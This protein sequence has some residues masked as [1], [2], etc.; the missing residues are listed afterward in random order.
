MK[1]IEILIIALLIGVTA[2]LSAQNTVEITEAE[3][4]IWQGKAAL[5]GYSP[6]GT[7][8]LEKGILTLDN[9][10][11][12]SLVVAVDMTT[13]SQE[14][15]RL[16]G[17]LRNEDFF[18]VEVFTQAVFTLTKP[19][20]LNAEETQLEGVMTIKNNSMNEVIPAKLSIVDNSIV[21][22]FDHQFDRTLY[23]ITYNSPT[24]FEKL[25][26]KAIAD[27]FNLRAKLS[28]PLPSN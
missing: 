2:D 5:G 22:S 18:D 26:D 12:T 6:E 10:T 4:I 3:P 14:N 27:E 21:I 19:V 9:N 17:H 15:K 1:K 28:F 24:Y 13:L 25:K 11:I 23:G 7:L 20:D 16:E 8:E